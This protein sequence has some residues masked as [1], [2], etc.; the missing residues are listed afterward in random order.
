MTSLPDLPDEILS[1]IKRIKSCFDDDRSLHA[2][3]DLAKCQELAA[4]AGCSEAFDQ[5][6]RADA[7]MRVITAHIQ[8]LNEALDLVRNDSSGQRLHLRSLIFAVSFNH[9]CV[10]L[11]IICTTG[12]QLLHDDRS[13][14]R[15]LQVPSH[16]RTSLPPPSP[17]Q[18][19]VSHLT[20]KSSP[21]LS[22]LLQIWHR[23]EGDSPVH[24]FKI[25]ATIRAPAQALLALIS[26]V[27]L[28]STL[29]P[30]L[31]KS[32][33]VQRLGRAR[34]VANVVLKGTVSFTPL[35]EATSAL[36]GAPSCA[37]S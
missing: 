15:N 29:F 26:E 25:S 8:M 35:K 10:I 3:D 37:L 34:R 12:W 30:F 36:H 17:A 5:F 19:H 20:C 6:V 4:H 11:L 13:G 18:Q 9:D 32:L 1:L 27:D 31:S 22:L 24:G 7:Q 23:A 14:A 21:I 28:Y 16:S 2:R 33:Q